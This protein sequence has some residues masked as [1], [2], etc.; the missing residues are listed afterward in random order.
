MNAK[1]CASVISISKWKLPRKITIIFEYLRSWIRNGAEVFGMDK[2]YDREIKSKQQI[3]LWP[4]E[5]FHSDSFQWNDFDSTLI[6]PVLGESN[7]NRFYFDI[8]IASVN[9]A[10]III[11]DYKWRRYGVKWSESVQ[12]HEMG[13]LLDFLGNAI[14]TLDIV[15]SVV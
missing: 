5:N 2:Y 1:K 6:H 15:N 13:W 8:L 7:T 9:Y 11:F 14:E 10:W 4:A 3:S 12:N